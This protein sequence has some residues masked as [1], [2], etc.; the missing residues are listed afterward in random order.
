MMEALPE[1]RMV[2]LVR[3]P[4]D[5]IASYIDARSEGGWNYERNKRQYLEGRRLPADKDPLAFAEERAARYLEVMGKAKEAYDTHQG[6]KV[7]V[8]YV[9]LR[10]DTLSTM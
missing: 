1:S 10:T 2:L 6:R 5:V 4:R 8:R 3:D 7:L 9:E